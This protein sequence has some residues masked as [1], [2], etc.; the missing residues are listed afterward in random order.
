MSGLLGLGEEI[1]GGAEET[2]EGFEGEG[3]G[4]VSEDEAECLFDHCL[5]G[6][7]NYV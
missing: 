3:F 2:G 7:I 4:G 1:G 6:E 5:V